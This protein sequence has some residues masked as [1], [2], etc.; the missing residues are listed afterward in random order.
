MD[1]KPTVTT[2]LEDMAMYLAST[3]NTLYSSV[4]CGSP[5]GNQNTIYQFM[6]APQPGSLV[7]E[8]TFGVLSLYRDDRAGVLKSM[9]FL[10][11]ITEEPVDMEWDEKT[12]GKPH[13]KETVYYVTNFDGNDCR[14]ANCK[15]I[16][17]PTKDILR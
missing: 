11:T 3:A 12:E 8:I 10:K 16:A 15:F 4:L 14:W 5:T 13:P 2:S 9:G 6:K 1:S 7:F 17:I